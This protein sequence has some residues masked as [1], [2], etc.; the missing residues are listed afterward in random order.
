MSSLLFCP[1]AAAG[2]GTLTNDGAEF[3][4]TGGAGWATGEVGVVEDTEGESEGEGDMGGEASA[5]AL[6]SGFAGA[7]VDGDGEVD[8]GAP[9]GAVDLLAKTAGE[10]EGEKA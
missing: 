1:V 2:L 3:V 5:G 6:G 7:I 4:E 8:S 10:V 9:R